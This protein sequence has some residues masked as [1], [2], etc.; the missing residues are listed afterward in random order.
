MEDGQRWITVHSQD[1]TANFSGFLKALDVWVEKPHVVNRRLTGAL[2]VRRTSLESLRI[3][4]LETFL[5]L[6]QVEFLEQDTGVRTAK[7]EE[8]KLKKNQQGKDTGIE[9]IDNLERDGKDYLMGPADRDCEGKMNDILV[10]RKL[11]PRQLHKQDAMLELVILGRR[12][13][14][15]LVQKY[16]VL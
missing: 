6:D 1:T 13:I 5:I 15:P 4:D 2:I 8:L 9:K 11:L 16:F 12:F 10:L 14:S 3:K 7:C